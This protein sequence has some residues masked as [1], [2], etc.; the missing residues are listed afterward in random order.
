MGHDWSPGGKQRLIARLSRVHGTD[1]VVFH[2]GSH[3]MLNADRMETVRALEHWLPR[4][5]DRGLRTVSLD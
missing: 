3:T 4:W 2:D 1:V 5:K